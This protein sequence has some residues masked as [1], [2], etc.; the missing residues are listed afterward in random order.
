[1]LDAVGGVEG[2]SKKVRGAFWMEDATKGGETRQF[3]SMTT[4]K[5]YRKTLTLVLESGLQLT[6]K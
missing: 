6:P 1:M 5:L 3:N 2:S 4:L